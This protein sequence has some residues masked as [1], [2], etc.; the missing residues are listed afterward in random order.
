VVIVQPITQRKK[1]HRFGLRMQW[2]AA[3]AKILAENYGRGSRLNQTRQ[4]P[5]F[6]GRASSCGRRV[7]EEA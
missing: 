4:A 2:I 5:G 1:Q 3:S 6:A 7:S